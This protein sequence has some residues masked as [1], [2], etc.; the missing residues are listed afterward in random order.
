MKVLL[1][2]VKSYKINKT[3]GVNNTISTKAIVVTIIIIIIIRG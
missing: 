3:V 1:R 2:D